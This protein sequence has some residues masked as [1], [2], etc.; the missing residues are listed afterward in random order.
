[1]S[2]AA[3]TL[4]RVL[5]GRAPVPRKFKC[6][7]DYRVTYYDGR[8]HTITED[9]YGPYGDNFVFT[10]DGVEIA[11]IARANVES[12]VLVDVPEAELP[13]E[14]PKPPVGFSR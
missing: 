2:V 10:L 8:A 11:I 6:T 13:A 3:G 7:A 4:E 5:G 9:K 12:V 14:P 1:M